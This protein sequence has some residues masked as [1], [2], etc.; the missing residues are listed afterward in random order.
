MV[1]SAVTAEG[2]R[3]D[4]RSATRMAGVPCSVL[5]FGPPSSVLRPPS[6]VLRPPSSVLGS[7]SWSQSLLPVPVLCPW[8]PAS[9]SWPPRTPRLAPQKPA[10]RPALRLQCLGPMPS[11]N[12]AILVELFRASPGLVS[13]VLPRLGVNLPDAMTSRCWSPPCRSTSPTSTPTSP[14]PFEMAPPRGPALQEHPQTGHLASLPG[15]SATQTPVR[16]RHPGHLARCERRPVGEPH[17]PRRAER[18]L[19]TRR[20]RTSRTAVSRGARAA[21][22]LPRPRRPVPSRPR[23]ACRQGRLAPGE[24]ADPGPRVL[25]RPP[26][27]RSALV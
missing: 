19:R 6:S 26:I 10:M 8:P 17:G 12:H 22:R 27:L 2:W 11:R 20:A 15:R 7:P 23:T 1:A 18:Q 13:A 3:E 14:S 5:V 4:A 24:P 21:G 9:P 25:G 16:S